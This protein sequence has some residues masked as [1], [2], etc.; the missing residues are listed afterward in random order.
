MERKVSIIGAGP[1]GFA[2]AADLQNRGIDVL[3]YS[4][5]DHFRYANEVMVKGQLTVRGKI[6]SSMPVCITSDMAEIIEFSLMIILTI[7]STGHETVLQQLR[8]FSLQQHTIIAIPG[9]LFSLIADI[10]IGC[11]LET[12]LSPYSCRMERDEVLVLGKKSLIFIAALQSPPS[13]AIYDAVQE[14]MPVKLC[15]CSSVIEVCLLNVNGVFHPL[16]ILMNAARIE[17]TNGDFFLYRDGLTSSVAK[18]MIAVDQVRMQIGNAFGHSMRSAL[19]VSNECYGH[20]FTSL[21]DLARNSG[22]HNGL[23]APPD[24][25]NRNISEDVPDLLVCWHSLAEKLGIDASPIKAIIVLAQMATSV[26]YF[27]S[28]RSLR[29]LHL[30]DISRSELIERF[31]AQPDGAIVSRL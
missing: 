9:N 31:M 20:T 16:M 28:G 7:P 8:G 14:I 4:H 15:W 29:K 11:V 10:E 27:Q 24:L 17:S 2:L 18:A 5:P 13:Q 23:K 19:R 25:Q 6:E 3:V 21:V 22:P 1:S 12:N 30:E 26:D